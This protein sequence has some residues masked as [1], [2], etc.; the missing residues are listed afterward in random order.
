MKKNILKM[1]A[2][3][4]LACLVLGGCALPV[5]TKPAAAKEESAGEAKTENAAAD[6]AAQEQPAD[7]PGA[8]EAPAQAEDVTAETEE[9]GGSGEADA[10]TDQEEPAP[11]EAAQETADAGQEEA[12][13][14][15]EEGGNTNMPN[16]FVDCETLEDAA[17]I[18][19]FQM[20]APLE[21]EG[22]PYTKI[23]AVENEMIQVFYYESE[24]AE[25]EHV[26]LRKGAGLEDISGDYNEYASVEEMTLGGRAVTAR[27]D[28]ERIFA[29]VWSDGTY[30]FAAVSADGMTEDELNGIVRAVE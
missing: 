15:G 11:E 6:T 1:I 18:A 9:A 2:M 26:L 17:E 22:C 10:G 7:D 13:G 12:G 28:G 25:T 4:V 16:P 21:L 23:Q 27:G 14:A 19:G 8:A 5:K 20:W 24:D 3:S 30:S 29:A